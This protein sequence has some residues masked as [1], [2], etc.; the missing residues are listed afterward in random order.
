MQGKSVVQVYRTI[1]KGLEMGLP[2]NAAA[3]AG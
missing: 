3:L 2:A 1:S